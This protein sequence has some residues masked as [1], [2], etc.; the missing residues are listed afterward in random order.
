MTL[1]LDR[2][3]PALGATLADRLVPAVLA[4]RLGARSRDLA[5][6]AASALLIACRPP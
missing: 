3:A 5:L 6:V 2:R 1:T 4:A